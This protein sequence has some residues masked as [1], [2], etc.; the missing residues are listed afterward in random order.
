MPQT[1][2][3]GPYSLNSETIDS[4]VAKTSPG[5]YVLGYVGIGGFFIPKHVGR[6]DD[7]ISDRLKDCVGGKYSKFKFDY[8]DSP[9]AAFAKECCLYHDWKEQLDNDQHPDRPENTR[10]RCPEC[11][12][13]K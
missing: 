11:D 5:V 6:S 8:Y 10:C 9:E 13:F 3:E 1:E 7:S 12:V 2:L 4:V